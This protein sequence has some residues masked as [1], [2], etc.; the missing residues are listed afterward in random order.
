MIGHLGAGRAESV[1]GGGAEA[2]VKAVGPGWAEGD[3]GCRF[4]PLPG[5]TTE[6]GEPAESRDSGFKRTVSGQCH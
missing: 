4:L 2:P 3:D 6:S 1:G 5:G